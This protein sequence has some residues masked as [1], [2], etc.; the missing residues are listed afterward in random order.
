MLAKGYSSQLVSP[1][2]GWLILEPQGLGVQPAAL[3]LA[4]LAPCLRLSRWIFVSIVR[5]YVHTPACWYIHHSGG[6]YAVAIV[7]AWTRVLGT[8][9]LEDV[10]RAKRGRVYTRDQKE[11]AG[12]DHI[13]SSWKALLNR[14]ERGKMWKMSL[15]QSLLFF[16]TSTH[17]LCRLFGRPPQSSR[18]PSA[19]A[20]TCT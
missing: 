8:I 4:G 1:D 13:E 6:E 18:D 10:R 17:V 20:H 2:D 5:E 15:T 14:C 11:G 9:I 16:I 7:V 19:G 3:R 12:V